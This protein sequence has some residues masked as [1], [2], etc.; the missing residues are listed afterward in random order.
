MIIKTNSPEETKKL[1]A[2]IAQENKG[3]IFALF[4]D[5]GAGK[6]AFV[7][8]FAKGLN[9]K[10]KILSPTFVFIREHNIPNTNRKLYHLDLYRIE[11]IDDIQQL[12]IQDLLNSDSIVLIEWAEKI[13]KILPKNTT[14]IRIE[15]LKSDG[16]KITIT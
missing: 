9:I 12:G 15:K 11:N 14:K 16:R 6:T 4:G 1:A 2:S 8:G 5:L 7:Q 13:E 3:N 10:D